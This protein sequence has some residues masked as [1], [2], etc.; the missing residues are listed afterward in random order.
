MSE[1]ENFELA[2]FKEM[3]KGYDESF[4]NMRPAPEYAS[5]EVILSSLYRAVGLPGVSEGKVPELG[6]SFAHRVKTGET[7][8][9]V[10]DHDTWK[11][12]L[13]KTLESPKL[14]SQSTKRFM[15]LCPVAPGVAAYSGSARLTKNSWNPGSLV[16]RMVRLGSNSNEEA[17]QTWKRLFNS[18][19][20]VDGVDDPWANLLKGEF[21]CWEEEGRAWEYNTLKHVPHLESWQS[22]GSPA[23][24]FVQDLGKVLGL[25]GKLTRRQW[26]SIVESLLRVASVSHVMWLC[27]VNERAFGVLHG[28]LRGQPPDNVTKLQECLF[29]S[30]PAT[31]HLGQPILPAVRSLARDYLAARVGI[32]YLLY[33]AED[34]GFL[35]GG[36]NEEIGTPAWFQKFASYIHEN[37]D[38]FNAL[39]T[40]KK[41][42]FLVEKDP[43]ILACKK[44]IGKNLVEFSRHVLGHR[45]AADE[46]L[47]IYDQ[48]F[49]AEKSANYQ[50]APWV[51]SLG[52]AA[53]MMF[54][55]CCAAGSHAPRTV[56]NLCEHLAEYGIGVKPN[57]LVLSEL[58]QTLRNLGLVLDS[59]DA[60]GGMV[61]MDPFRS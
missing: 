39:Q 57:D 48:G 7:E 50:S 21:H 1:L 30:H 28:A 33:V 12:V 27:R 38:K 49:F 54:C 41:H 17:D 5:G 23:S 35:F 22:P 36:E 32:N 6:Q 47:V 14:P 37:R 58:G 40:L 15:L 60:E 51:L 46:R 24:Q 53:V 2:P 61:V 10:L 42:Q 16:H 26:I 18:L 56:E 25:K 45:Q 29:A 34:M 11:I 20:V 19:S 44:G 8:Q 59:P 4:L 55:H 52:P 13:Y 43:R 9:N 31:W 3:H